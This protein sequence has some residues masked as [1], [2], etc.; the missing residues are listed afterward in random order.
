MLLE[1]DNSAL[2]ARS[3]WV[4]LPIALLVVVLLI[5]DSFTSEVGA[6]A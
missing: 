5:L 1:L 3:H 2:L 6:S 4:Y